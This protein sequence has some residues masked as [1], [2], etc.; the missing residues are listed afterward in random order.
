MKRIDRIRKESQREWGHKIVLDE[1]DFY[2]LIGAAETIIEFTFDPDSPYWPLAQISQ[3]L[4][5]ES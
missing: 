5:E 4:T 1:K 2:L 3:W